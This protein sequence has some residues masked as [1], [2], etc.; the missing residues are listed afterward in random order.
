MFLARWQGV[1]VRGAHAL[2]LQ[3][4]SGPLASASYQPLPPLGHPAAQPRQAI[5]YSIHCRCSC[6]LQPPIPQ[7][8]VKILLESAARPDAVETALSTD[9]P[10]L[11]A[12]QEVRSGGVVGHAQQHVAG[13]LRG[14]EKG[15]QGMWSAA[16]QEQPPN[17]LLSCMAA[18]H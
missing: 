12:L 13:V 14:D 15:W 3:H 1:Q 11:E 17:P 16:W 10:M 2:W 5:R 4:S 7:V 18:D 6:L 8:A 9:H